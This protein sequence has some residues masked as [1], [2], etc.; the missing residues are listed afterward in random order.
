VNN[1]IQ[2]PYLCQA[3]NQSFIFFNDY[4]SKYCKSLASEKN[5]IWHK[6]ANPIKFFREIGNTKL[7]QV[8]I[9]LINFFHREYFSRGKA[10][11]LKR[12]NIIK[13]AKLNP[14]MKPYNLSRVI[15]RL[16]DRGIILKIYME[17]GGYKRVYLL[18]N[19]HPYPY[20]KQEIDQFEKD[21]EDMIFSYEKF[22]KYV[23]EQSNGD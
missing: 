7:S 23:T 16:L 1:I 21:S 6:K 4:I 3:K 14:D 17:T 19:T 11:W 12:K 20:T 22:N 18:P 13:Q 15:K 5:F 8:Q 9:K 10:C 2:P